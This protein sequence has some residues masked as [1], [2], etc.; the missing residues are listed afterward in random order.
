MK[1]QKLLPFFLMF[2]GVITLVYFVL[3][4]NMLVKR[5][6]VTIIAHDG[7]SGMSYEMI[8]PDLG[9]GKYNITFKNGGT[10]LHDLTAI[11]VVRV[12]LKPGEE[13]NIKIDVPEEGLVY[14]CTFFGHRDMGMIGRFLSK[15][16]VEN[17]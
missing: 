2:I 17:L 6:D 1:R 9:P 14:W 10:E 8:P 13:A 12:E 7:P 11:G 16:E 5:V 4:T 15:K 3:S